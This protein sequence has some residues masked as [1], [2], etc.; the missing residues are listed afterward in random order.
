MDNT[1]LK[2]KDIFKKDFLSQ[3]SV[4]FSEK[5]I[6]MTIGI[7]FLLG[8]FIFYVYKKTFKGILYSKSF[9]ISL[10]MMSM[11][12]SLMIMAITSNIVLSLG[13]VGA[14]SIVRFRTAIKD[15]IDVVFMFW[16]ITVGII[17]GAGIFKLAIWGSI[18]IA[19]LVYIIHIKSHGDDAYILVVNCNSCKTEQEIINLVKN[20]AKKIA[21]KSKII[22]SDNIEL[23]LE[24]RLKEEQDKLV[25]DINSIKNVTSAVLI[26]YNG[27]YVS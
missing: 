5:Q 4:D 1:T 26:S 14:L 12:T 10:I 6:I 9:N 21:I 11:I 15:P 7:A 18:I 20:K 22:T 13:M 16:S 8:F 2:F 24:V 25:N 27:D 23:T 3:F 19:A 17:T